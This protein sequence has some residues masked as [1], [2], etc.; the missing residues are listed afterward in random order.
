MATSIPANSRRLV[1]TRDAYHCVRCG[2]PTMAGQWH[3]RRS[4]SVRDEH[5]HCPCNGIWLCA[6]CHKWVHEHPF[7]ARGH[8]WIVSRHKLPNAEPLQ[9]MRFGW[10][11]LTCSGKRIGREAPG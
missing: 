7:E 9:N 10:V 5:Q 6:T 3:H 4:R 8:G 11:M 2:I 1:E